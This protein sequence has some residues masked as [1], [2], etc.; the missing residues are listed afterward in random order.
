MDDVSTLKVQLDESVDNEEED[1]IDKD[2]NYL[3]FFFI[4][5]NLLFS[6]LLE[7]AVD[8]FLPTLKFKK[9]VNEINFLE[10]L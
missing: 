5:F 10:L 8:I 6:K 7:S 1:D 3:R 4:N 9:N 2:E